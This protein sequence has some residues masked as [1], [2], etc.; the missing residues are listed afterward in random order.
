MKKIFLF[1]IITFLL[2]LILS[3]CNN[4]IPQDNTEDIEQSE[5]GPIET[6]D[7]PGPAP[8]SGDGVSDGSGWKG[9]LGIFS[10]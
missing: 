5:E 9:L 4:I 3:G 2:I 6:G 1:F 10:S 7:N 8:N